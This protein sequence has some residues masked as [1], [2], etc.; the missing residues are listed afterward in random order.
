[1]SVE[2][3]IRGMLLVEGTMRCRREEARPKVGERIGMR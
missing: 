1:M 2:G 3:E